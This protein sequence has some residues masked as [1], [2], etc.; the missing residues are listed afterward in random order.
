M[1]KL[2]FITSND[3]SELQITVDLPVA[4]MLW[5][6]LEA[7]NTGQLTDGEFMVMNNFRNLLLES[8]R[9]MK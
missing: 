4:D 9:E 6:L 3:Y 7:S 8:I 1:A 5:Q 2:S